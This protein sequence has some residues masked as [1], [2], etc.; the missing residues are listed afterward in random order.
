MNTTDTTAIRTQTDT[1]QYN[2][3]STPIFLTSSFVFDD[4]EHMRA[5]FAEEVDGNIYSRFTNPT[6]SEFVQ[7]M[8]AL[9]GAEAGYATATGMAAIFG[10]IMGLLQSGDHI[11]A[12][13]AVFGSTHALL[14]QYLPK[15][16]ITSTYVDIADNDR[17]A[18]AITPSTK[19]LLVETPSN[20]GL[21]IADLSFL[22]KLAA[23]HNIILN[24]DNCFATPLLQRPID[25]GAHIVTHSATKW[26]DGQ[27]RVLGGVILGNADLL[28]SIYLFCRNTGPSMSP[29]T[30][31]ILSKSLETLHVRLERHCQSAHR[32]AEALSSHPRLQSVRYPGLPSHPQ[33][34]LAMSQMSTG[35]GIVAIDV[36]G[37]A[38]AAAR[39][40]D[41]VRMASITANI[42]DTRTIVTHPATSTH[43]KLTEE[44]R[45]AVGITPGLIRISVGLEDVRDIINDLT[46]AIDAVEQQ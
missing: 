2:E 29:F 27:G 5:M 31:W 38:A 13:R 35:G 30:A 9:E 10:S 46:Q 28:R 14:T 20:P 8:C 25:Y 6:T 1:T 37:G 36:K 44:A 32:V 45:L 40:I 21:D 33:Y 15:W 34:T 3:H 18:A 12:S 22:G 19:M 17:W 42:G 7:K 16:G 11:V 23:D 24:V 41:S 4:A 39:V 26:I 43:S